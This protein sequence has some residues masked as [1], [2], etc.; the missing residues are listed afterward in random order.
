MAE[1]LRLVGTCTRCGTG[2]LAF[3]EELDG[4]TATTPSMGPVTGDDD[5]IPPHL[6]MGLPR[7]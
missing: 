1:G 5:L 2:K 3:R 7:R 6:V 4:P